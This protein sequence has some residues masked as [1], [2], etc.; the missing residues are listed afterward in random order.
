MHT[1]RSDSQQWG[2]GD[3]QE[4]AGVVGDAWWVALL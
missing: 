3:V 1:P 2:A 4:G